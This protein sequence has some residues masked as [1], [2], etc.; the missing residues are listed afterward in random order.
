[1]KEFPENYTAVLTGPP[2]VGKHLYLLDLVKFYLEKGESITYITTERSPNEVKEIA[3]KVGLDLDQYEG[4]KFIFIDLYS[5][6]TGERYDNGFSIDNPANLNLITVNLAKAADIVGKP[7]RVFFD[8]LSSLFLHAPEP[9]I[10]KFFGVLS[11]RVKTDYGFVIYTIQDEMHDDQTVIAL[12]HMV[13][14]VLEMRFEE[15]PPLKNLFRVHHA[16]GMETKP[17]WFE[18]EVSDKGFKILKE[19][20]SEKPTAAAP[21]TVVVEKPAAPS[22]VMKFGALGFVFLLVAGGFLMFKGGG[23]TDEGPVQI[24]DFYLLEMDKTVNVNGEDVT[25]F[26]DMKT[27]ID[28]RAPERGWLLIENPFYRIELNLD[29]PYYRLFDKVADKE[30]TLFNDKVESQI[31]MI[32]GSDLGYADHTGENKVQFSTT[33]LHD[34]DGIPRHTIVYED[35]PN[36]FVLLDTEGWDFIPRDPAA[37]YDAEA[38]VMLGLFA[39]KPYFID[40]MEFNNLQ[41]LGFVIQ[42]ASRDPDEIVRSWVL[43]PDYSSAIIRGGDSD[44]LNKVLYDDLY[45][46]QPISEVARK[47]Y[48]F[49]SAAISKMFPDDVLF[50]NKQGSGVVFTLPQG[51]PRWDDSKGVFGEQVTGEYILYIEKPEKAIAWTIEPVNDLEFL[52]DIVEFSTVPGYPESLENILER[53]DMKYPGNVIDAHN[54]V[55]KRTAYVI[56][57]VPSGWYNAATNKPTDETWELVDEASSDY[58]KYEDIIYTQLGSTKPIA[59]MLLRG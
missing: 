22:N 38:E 21:T 54:W 30:V 7:M 51:W 49:G 40:A 55:T 19:F 29:H 46:V 2:G 8:S 9:E 43:S 56:T 13:D 1:M 48:H 15:G 26:I 35:K 18:V 33:A 10:K 6:S 17:T 3:K 37:G 42:R 50:G 47:P 39:D 25:A 24:S 53:Y 57:L 12:K 20:V 52:Y 23:G 14:G 27:R 31:D 5:H 44:H 34:V 32:T 11:S 36:G 59:Q 58:K 41:M 4:S 45:Q 28:S 16:K